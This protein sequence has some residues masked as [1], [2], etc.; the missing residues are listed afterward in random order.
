[1]ADNA[2]ANY[3]VL[4]DTDGNKYYVAA[5]SVIQPSTESFTGPVYQ[6]DQATT[7]YAG[8]TLVLMDTSN[9]AAL[10]Q[11]LAATVYDVTTQG[12][13]VS[14]GSNLNETLL[15]MIEAQPTW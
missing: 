10:F 14:S 3:Y 15:A 6:D 5:G 12:T 4:E 8:R 9:V 1:I 13:S 7:L 11:P 2:N